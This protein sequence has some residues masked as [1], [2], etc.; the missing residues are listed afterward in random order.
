MPLTISKS[1]ERMW[2]KW[3]SLIHVHTTHSSFEFAFSIARIALRSKLADI[4][5]KHA[6]Y[7]EDEGK[8]DEAEEEFV[9]AGKPKEAVLMYVHQQNWDAA[10]R[11]AETHCPD[12]VADVLVGQVSL[13]CYTLPCQLVYQGQ[14][15]VTC[16]LGVHLKEKTSRKQ[17]HSSWG[18][19]DQNWQPSFTRWVYHA[20]RS[21]LQPSLGL[22][23]RRHVGWC[24]EDREGIYSSQAGRISERNVSKEW[25]VS[26]Q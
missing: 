18:P 12:S 11:V 24:F 14:H 23:G 19:R 13:C 26:F 20:F 3:Y 21:S 1:E 7:L 22:L 5:L 17:R 16:R 9:A 4:H 8:Y 6:L 2:K 10:Q 25:Q 15:D